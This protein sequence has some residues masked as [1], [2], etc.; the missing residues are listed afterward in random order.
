MGQQ[1]VYDFLLKHPDQWYTSKQISE[2]LIVSIGSVT[3][4]LK[5]LRKTN[6]IK[7]RNTGKRNTFQ[8]MVQSEP[9]KLA[10]RKMPIMESHAQIEAQVKKV[11][12]KPKVVH[13]HS[14]LG[15][16][17]FYGVIRGKDEV[18]AMDRRDEPVGGSSFDSD[19][20][21]EIEVTVQIPV[22][23]T[24]KRTMKPKKVQ[25]KIKRV[26]V[27]KTTKKK[28]HAGTKRKTTARKIVRKAT[29]KKTLKR[30]R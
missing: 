11:K 7:F 29:T 23:R 12:I 4:S 28:M 2:Q 5:K 14:Y 9:A 18:A 10:E 6:I 20:E 16:Q 21:K 25:K 3:M 19:E 1:E 30:K 8:Y 15:G 17:T 24:V 26:A 13:Q 22:K 27:K